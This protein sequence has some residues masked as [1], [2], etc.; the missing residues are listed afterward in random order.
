[1]TEVTLTA[2]RK[3]PKGAKCSN[4]RTI[5]LI[6]H[7]VKIVRRIESKIEDVLREDW[8]GF[9]MRKGT[10]DVTQMLRIILK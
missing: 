5:S 9:R 1:L 3:K 6:A 2:L 4:H 8:F 10:S 7:T